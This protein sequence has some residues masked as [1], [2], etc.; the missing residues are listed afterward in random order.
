MSNKLAEVTP[1]VLEFKYDPAKKYDK[2]LMNIKNICDKNILAKVF[3]SSKA[4]LTS[5]TSIL[6]AAPGEE[7]EIVFKFKGKG[8]Q[9]TV[10]GS[11]VCLKI[12]PVEED[13]FNNN[14]E[15]KAKFKTVDSKKIKEIGQEVVLKTKG[16]SS[17]NEALSKSADDASKDNLS[18]EEAKKRLGDLKKPANETNNANASKDPVKILKGKEKGKG[19]LISVIAVVAVLIIAAVVG[20]L[21]MKNKK[22]Q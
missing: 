1:S 8:T 11:K 15:M 21:V 20:T 7:K 19:G 4:D 16:D 17:A 22:N 10:D 5:N 2:A 14:D 9:T 12:I 13:G 3:I 6:F 18:S